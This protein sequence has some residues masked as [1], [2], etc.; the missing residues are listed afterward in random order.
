MRLFYLLL[1]FSANSHAVFEKPIEGKQKIEQFIAQNKHKE[2][3]IAT[4][5]HQSQE[6][7]YQTE[8]EKQA[9]WKNNLTISEAQLEKSATQYLQ[10]DTTAQKLVN[11]EHNR[12][13]FDELTDAS[14]TNKA[15]QLSAQARDLLEL[16]QSTRRETTQQ[17]TSQFRRYICYN[18]RAPVRANCLRYLQSP[19]VHV[20]PA[21]Y[22][23]FWCT[24]GNHQPDD[25]RCTAQE[26]YAIPREYKAKVVTISPDLWVSECH[27]FESRGAECKVIESHCL[28]KEP[29]TINGEVI[30]RPCWKYQYRYECKYA[31][32]QSCEPYLRQGCQ[33]ANSECHKKIGNKCQIWQQTYNCPVVNPVNKIQEVAYKKAFCQEGEC[34]DSGY[35]PN[36][37]LHTAISQL[38]LFSHMQSDIRSSINSIF[39]GKS[40]G[41]NKNIVNFK[42]CCNLSGWGKG[43]GLSNCGEEAEK[44]VYQRGKKHCVRVGTYCAEKLPIVGC[45]REKTNFC[46][47]NNKLTRIFH[48]QGRA[49]LHKSWGSAENPSCLGFSPAELASI[50]FSKI[51]FTEAY[52]E[53]KMTAKSKDS[54][55]QRLQ[56]KLQNIQNNFETQMEGKQ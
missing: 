44:L 43:L 10:Q 9:L 20:T 47:Y 14:L 1:L 8:S 31:V 37:E 7:K 5:V 22:S 35:Q 29:R 53:I 3:N 19:S 27:Q 49:Q 6:I 54:I 52:D 56:N 50:D 4:A 42:D 51:D 30:A 41:C 25:P 21:K 32:S 13:R 34:F 36:N 16:S 11:M 24:S 39:N 28:D 26:Y 33:P 40:L 12:P 45:I 15:G 17:K 48:E 18:S 2:Q 23:H 55:T 46:C 38:S